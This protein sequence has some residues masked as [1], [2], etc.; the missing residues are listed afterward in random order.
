[1]VADLHPGDP[2]RSHA[3]ALLMASEAQRESGSPR[4]GAALA[5]AAAELAESQGEHEVAAQAHALRALHQVRMGEL[6]SAVASGQQALACF[7]PLGLS[8]ARSRAHSTLSLAYE[9]AGLKTLAVTQAATAL[10]M[11]RDVKD[12]AA[13]CWALIR[14]GS[15]AN[16][17]EDQHGLDLLGEA[18]ELARRLPQD[19][20]EILF[21]A[22]NNL[23]RRWVVEADRM[24]ADPTQARGNL[25]LALPLAEEAAQLARHGFAVATA[26][27]NLGGVHRRLGHAAEAGQHFRRA[28][29]EAESHGYAGLAATVRVALASLDLETAPSAQRREA[30]SLLLDAPAAGIDPD[31]ALQARRTLVEGC[32]Q[33]G[34]AQAALAHMERLHAEVQAT[35]ARRSN[36]QT[37]LLFNHAELDQARHASERA[38][39][40]AELERLRA[41]AERQTAQRLAVDRSLLE[42]E[43]AARTADLQRATQAAEAAN[44]AKS[45]FLSII[46]HEFRN[47]LNGLIGMLE[48][49]RRRSVDQR[50]TDQLLK[51][52][53]AARQLSGIFDSILNYVDADARPADLQTEIDL[54]KLLQAA[55]QSRTDAA[56]TRGLDLQIACAV[57]L[58]AQ[59]R[60]DARRLGEILDA[61]LDN[62]LKF[63]SPGPVVLEAAWQPANPGLSQLRLAVKDTGPGLAP[64]LRQRLFHPFELGDSSTTRT[65]GGLGLGLALAQRLAQSL[66]GELGVEGHPPAGTCFW[67][68]IPVHR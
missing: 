3:H 44:S 51:A 68:S 49:A 39:L 37:R 61:L 42:R 4:E 33:M 23:S 26:A 5:K 64:D 21:S 41:D 31:L 20:E 52:T 2:A 57:E 50:Q 1:M 66:G 24:A 9:R 8:A 34:D 28:L 59:V 19:D 67:V 10:E 43:V 14:L 65:Q 58:P 47:P 36:L 56:L 13:E 29:S 62:A 17:A 22:L 48:L 11:A 32:K 55:V 46:S 25:L 27:A 30:L 16:E 15:A 53:A 6:E 40:A 54:R 60:V 12:L 35:Q 7:G 63:S 38:R 45:T 18:L